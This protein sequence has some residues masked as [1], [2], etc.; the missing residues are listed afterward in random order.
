MPDQIP[1]L[2]ICT[3]CG[4]SKPTTEFHADN[5]RPDG[6]APQCVLCR[7]S[8][9]TSARREHLTPDEQKELDRL[10]LRE[11]KFNADLDNPESTS[12]ALRTAEIGIRKTI[13]KQRA[14]L[15]K[16]IAERLKGI[17]AA[18]L[19]RQQQV[20]LDHIRLEIPALSISPV[21]TERD[22]RI[23]TL[24]KRC[25]DLKGDAFALARGYIESQIARLTTAIES[26]RQAEVARV[27]AATAAKAAEDK[28]SGDK[29]AREIYDWAKPFLLQPMT[30]QQ[31]ET[32]KKFCLS[33]VEKAAGVENKVVAARM[34]KAY[35]K[36][37]RMLEVVTQDS[38]PSTDITEPG[39]SYYTSGF[40]TS[41]VNWNFR[42]SQEKALLRHFTLRCVGEKWANTLPDAPE[43]IWNPKPQTEKLENIQSRLDGA[44]IAAPQLE[45]METKRQRYWEELKRTNPKQY[46]KESRNAILQIKGDD[47]FAQRERESLKAFKER[48]PEAFE[49]YSLRMLEPVSHDLPTIIYLC[50]IWT[51]LNPNLRDEMRWPDGR[52]VQPHEIAYDYRTNTWNLP[53]EPVDAEIDFNKKT[54]PTDAELKRMSPEA[55]EFYRD[56]DAPTASKLF[57]KPTKITFRKGDRH[58]EGSGRDFFRH[59]S[60]WTAEDIERTETGWSDKPPVVLPPL[61]AITL[62]DSFATAPE[63]EAEKAKWREPVETCWQRLE[64]QRK[65]QKQFEAELVN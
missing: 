40:S 46:E 6:K 32:M 30:L 54:G 50:P 29:A 4:I 34:Q 59:G 1:A 44:A 65:E 31:R 36:L 51:H 53:A 2:K 18:E 14:A 25:D 62:A 61:P 9:A 27:E 43:P 19:G 24:Q 33:Q 45:E 12:N 3:K 38:L 48:N 7:K 35:A 20:E 42:T 64:R 16:Q 10:N 23:L 13:P 52:V 26:E 47:I 56:V 17:R 63:T 11:A 15:E 37:A 21:G 41:A 57:A 58:I 39:T 55:A 60:W 28:A 49:K 22:N 8:K 5:R